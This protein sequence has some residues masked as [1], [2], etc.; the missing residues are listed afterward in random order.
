[1]RML[2]IEQPLLA[3]FVVL[4]AGTA[5]GAVRVAGLSVGPA[6][7]LFAGLAL[8]A[9]VPEVA[10]VV[11]AV[12][13]TLGLTLFAYTVGLAGGPSFFAGLRRAA[14]IMI[15]AVAVFAGLAVAAH[16][17]GRALGLAP[18]DIAGTYAGAVTNTP[19]LAAAVE[20]TDTNEPVV[21]YSLAYPFGVVGVIL[22]IV[23]ALRWSQRAP[24]A[25]DGD[26]PQP[27]SHLTVEVTRQDLPPL[28]QLADQGEAQLVFSRVRRGGADRTP[29]P[30]FLLEPGDLVTV[31]GPQG[32]LQRFAKR[33][34]RPT[35]HDLP[36][37]RTQLDFRR[38]VLSN[39]KYAGA[40]VAE[41][42][43]PRFDAV[44]GYVRRGDVDLVAR[45]DLVVELG[46]RIRVVGP[47]ERIEDAAAELGGSERA[48]AVAEPVGFGLGL[49]LGLAL[50]V[51]PVPLPGMTLQLGTAAGPLL[52]GLVLGRVGRT[53]PVVWQLPYSTNQALRQLGVL[54]FLATVGLSAG[55]QLAGALATTRGMTLLA[56][57][58]G[59]TTAAAVS[60]LLLGR[61]L[62]LGGAR[63]AGTLAGGQNQ[64]AVLAFAV[65]R[66]NG[67][68]RVNLA[69]A[70]LFPPTFVVKILAAQVLAGL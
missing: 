42:G 49:L 37:D 21:G 19:G 54:L 1:M 15:V 10:G 47:R 45:P 56:F 52:V 59:L 20:V 7:T 22:T 23:V 61:W 11:P 12:L 57:G 8:S 58:A 68:D 30:D 63:L 41:L 65:D 60:L 2:L 17:A 34:G 3:L 31:I 36:L 50:G 26:P 62:Q 40:T 51:V 48:A 64:P 70:L 18:G 16:V 28:A 6:G 29:T 4:A 39:P 5:L 69:Y 44:A 43:L 35:P 38:V 33:L 46:D 13:G 24:T 66:T 9:L 27:A 25:E 67:D 53:G 14:P 32:P 55:P